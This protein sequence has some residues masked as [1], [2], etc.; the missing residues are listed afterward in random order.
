MPII[1]VKRPW[2][3]KEWENRNVYLMIEFDRSLYLLPHDELLDWVRTNANALN[4]KSWLQ[5]GQYHWPYA[6]KD[7][8]DFLAKYREETTEPQSG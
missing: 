2:I 5:E 8:Q 3:K 6:S 4:T 7:M 1:H